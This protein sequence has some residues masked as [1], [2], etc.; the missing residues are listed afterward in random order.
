MSDDEGIIVAEAF[1]V[2]EIDPADDD[3]FEI[4]NDVKEEVEEELDPVEEERRA[5]ELF[6]ATGIVQA[7]KGGSGKSYLEEMDEGTEVGYEA[8]KRKD[9]L[10]YFHRVGHTVAETTD[11]PFIIPPTEE[12]VEDLMLLDALRCS[13]GVAD[14]LEAA[15]LKNIKVKLKALRAAGLDEDAVFD[16]PQEFST[17]DE[18]YTYLNAQPMEEE[19]ED[20]E[21]EI[22]DEE[23][24]YLFDDEH[25]MYYEDEVEHVFYRP[26]HNLTVY[27]AVRPDV[28]LALLFLLLPSFCVCLTPACCF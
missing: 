20:E 5:Y 17:Q 7:K 16:N 2:E 26:E 11:K 27:D 25:E 21:Y 23:E 10:K 18:Y 24:H 3:F 15:Q 8:D 22:D 6:K 13:M 14:E 19:F 1:E 28:R 4:K 9:G 12:D